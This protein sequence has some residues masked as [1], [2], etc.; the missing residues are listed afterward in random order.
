MTEVNV[1]QPDPRTNPQGSP[2]GQPASKPTLEPAASVRKVKAAGKEIEIPESDVERYLSA[3]VVATQ[4]FQEAARLRQEAE[5]KQAQTNGYL[6]FRQ[7]LDDPNNQDRATLMSRLAEGEP[8]EDIARELAATYVAQGDEDDGPGM[9]YQ[10]DAQGV[11]VD[12][13]YAKLDK[14]LAGFESFMKDLVTEREKSAQAAQQAQRQQAERALMQEIRTAQK[15]DRFLIDAEEPDRDLW[16]EIILHVAEKRGLSTVQAATQYVGRMLGGISE[17]QFRRYVEVKREDAK[18][19]ASVPA[20][21]TPALARG[22]YKATPTSLQTGET[23]KRA[24][25]FLQQR[26]GQQR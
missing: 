18:A 25:A 2:A 4:R 11:R 8:L 16:D 23:R 24:M 7:F 17:K 10:E 1:G 14:R 3:G 5:E 22:G 15:Q 20:T 6:A 13:G 21:A 12:P 26:R 9:T 19:D